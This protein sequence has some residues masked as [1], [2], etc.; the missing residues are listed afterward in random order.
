[1]PKMRTVV[2]PILIL[3]LLITGMPADAD[4]KIETPAGKPVPKLE[5][6]QKIRKTVTEIFALT[7]IKNAERATA[8]KKLFKTAKETSD[9]ISRFVL[10]NMAKEQ[11]SKVGELYTAMDAITELAKEFE[12]D[13]ERVRVSAIRDCAVAPNLSAKQK[14]II[15][16]AADKIIDRQMSN[17]QYKK[18]AAVL[19]ILRDASLRHWRDPKGTDSL[20]ERM[21]RCIRL[22]TEYEKVRVALDQPVLNA[23][24]STTVG[25]FFVFHKGD[26]ESGLPYLAEGKDPKMAELAK[27]EL[28]GVDTVGVMMKVAD[29]WEQIG[30][31]LEDAEAQ[32]QALGRALGLYK[33]AIPK[34]TG[35]SLVKAQ[36][37]SQALEAKGIAAVV[38]GSIKQPE[39]PKAADAPSSPL[40]APN[41]AIATRAT[42]GP[43]GGLLDAR[44]RTHEPIDVSGLPIPKRDAVKGTWKFEDGV[45][46]SP[47]ERYARIRIPVIPPA[48][49]DLRFSVTTSQ[50]GGKEVFVTSSVGGN[51]RF[52]VAIDAYTQGAQTGLDL[53][54]G[55]PCFRNETRRSGEV[56]QRGAVNQVYI[57]VRKLG[58]Q[59]YVNKSKVFDWNGDIKRLTTDRDWDD[60]EHNCFI[61]GANRSEVSFQNISLTPRP[62]ITIRNA[63]FGGNGHW[64]DVTEKIKEIYARYDATFQNTSRGLST[65]DPWVGWKK[66]TVITYTLNGQEKK[67]WLSNESKYN[68]HHSLHESLP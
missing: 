7:T 60:S 67:R 66:K 53:I 15:Q 38:I 14:E 51:R 31:T 30:L 36:K 58:I 35:L 32:S 12:F 11:A 43:N 37:R 25:S 10:F 8:A 54:D 9:D 21:E 4:D 6:R 61:L 52:S 20:N 44:E 16:F 19:R 27:I 47:D 48:E 29:G 23:D 2:P 17:D 41:I 42:E 39:Q 59:L 49:Y 40:M 33:A 13:P 62:K 24:A 56:L 65:K 50:R 64:A 26:W 45:L 68:L 57:R 3:A 22:G 55:R 28:S 46:T 1:M 18:A 63:R 5:D 34:L